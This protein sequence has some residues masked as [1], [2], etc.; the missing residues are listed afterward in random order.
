MI[1]KAYKLKVDKS[2]LSKETLES[3]RRLF[4]EA[5]WYYNDL[6]ATGDVFH[7]DYKSRVVEVRNMDGNLEVRILR[8]LSSQM[9]Q[10]IVDRA[11]DAVRGL[12][13]LKKNGHKV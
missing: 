12:V 1:C 9:R 5:K 3:L 11:K 2:H 6:V 4:L 8:Y 13:Q 10:E 7:A